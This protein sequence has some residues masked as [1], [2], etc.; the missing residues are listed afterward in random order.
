MTFAPICRVDE[1]SM[2]G[3]A[4]NP[5]CSIWRLVVPKTRWTAEAYAGYVGLYKPMRVRV[6]AHTHEA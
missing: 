4:P 5:T 2:Y 3:R 1:G 6:H